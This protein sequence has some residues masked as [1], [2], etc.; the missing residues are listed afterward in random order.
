MT[1]FE[2]VPLPMRNVPAAAPLSGEWWTPPVI[3]EAARKAMG[4]IDMDPASSAEANKTVQ[5]SMIYTAQMDGLARKWSG[6][7]WC[8]PPFSEMTA[9][10]MHAMDQYER[11]D[12]QALC[13][14]GPWGAS[15]WQPRAWSTADGICLIDKTLP[16]WHG[17]AAAAS[18]KS[19]PW[20][21]GLIC[22]IFGVDPAP[23]NAVGVVR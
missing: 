10:A 17:P 20:G 4:S 15:R 22:C 9:W 23:F 16:G 5:A 3:I 14:L 2:N 6:R 11:G 12:I 13:L 7:V 1:G 18:P 19:D 8:N 21:Y